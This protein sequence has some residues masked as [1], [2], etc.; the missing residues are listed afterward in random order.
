MSVAT[1]RFGAPRRIRAG[2]TAAAL[3][4][5]AV[6]VAAVGGAA[7]PSARAAGT[8]V[9]VTG[10]APYWQADSA[11]TSFSNHSATFSEMTPF[12]FTAQAVNGVLAIVNLSSDA[13]LQQYKAAAAGK[14]VVATITDGSGAH[15]MAGVLNDPTAR[16]AHETDIVNLVVNNNLAGI[17]LDYEDFA[18]SDGRGS[19]PT[20]YANWGS[21]ITELSTA[22]HAAGKTL[23]VDVP[24]IYDN[25][26]TSSSGYWVYNF[27]VM[28]QNVDRIRIMTYSYSGS[29]AEP[30]APYQ[31]VSDSMDAALKVP[32]MTAAQLAMGIADYGNDAITKID[33]SC[34]KGTTLKAR[35]I[36]NISS[37]Q[38][39]ADRGATPT[40][41]A[42]QHEPTFSYVESYTGPD[43][44]AVGATVRCNVYR[45]V[46]FEDQRAI[47]E[48]VKLAQSKSLAGV[49][50]WAL[51][52]DNDLTWTAVSAAQTSVAFTQPAPLPPSIKAGTNVVTAPYP[53]PIDSAGPLPARYVDT[54]VGAKTAD[55]LMAGNGKM[56]AGDML[57]VQIGGRG[58]VPGDA[59]AVALN[60]TVLGQGTGYVTVY[61]CGDQ[62]LTS[63][64]NVKAGQIISNT[65]ITRLSASGTVCIY[66]QAAADIVVDV[67]NILPASA[68]QALADPVRLVDTRPGQSTID[69][70]SA[71]GGAIA[72]NGVLQVPIAGRGGLSAAARN[73][74]LNVT[75]VGAT[76]SGYLTVWPC[77][78]PQPSTSNVNFTAGAIIPN[79]VVTALGDDGSVC[80]FASNATHV[81]VDAF[82]QL[83]T[84]SYQPLA[85]PARLLET[86]PGYGTTDG[87][88]NN[89]GKMA[90]GSTLTLPVASR[91]GLAAS[92][93]TVV[94]NVTVDQ[95]ELAGYITVYPCGTARPAV[96]NVNFAPSQTLPNLVVTQV[97]ASG[98]VCIYANVKTHVIVDAFGSLST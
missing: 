36:T 37:A 19:W 90:A 87:Q 83:A 85:Q 9:D 23:A 72:R 97:S 38:Y 44:S 59:T 46:W 67:F 18:F 8:V 78:T 88:F 20:T 84:A 65:V 32:G 58:P 81:V 40:W 57:E 96:S 51:G 45:T 31:W 82:G 71:G 39:A 63:S 77:G 26:Q 92:P 75:A 42:V 49:A 93:S 64:L 3:V 41:D 29:A 79:A 1:L 89:V 76:G 2:L 28:A 6:T 66:S 61:P 56:N 12:F 34:P 94:L 22:L 47:Y 70:Q 14:P 16:A 48:R 35:G 4:A 98:T 7:A 69:G 74:V 95:P 68:F 73:A 43:A 27:P 52:Y 17:D 21:F 55:G 60:V 53:L 50:L 62:P 33:G 11:L 13:K 25:G 10:W 5:S 30:I 15:T 24:P 86:R 91:G 54:R 80:I